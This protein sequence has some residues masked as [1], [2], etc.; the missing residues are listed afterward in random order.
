MTTTEQADRRARGDRLRELREDRRLSQ[1]DLARL[2]GVAAKTI[3]NLESGRHGRP[4]R[5]TSSAVAKALGVTI[6]DLEAAS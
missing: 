4:W 5:R 3:H 2:A 6:E 1:E